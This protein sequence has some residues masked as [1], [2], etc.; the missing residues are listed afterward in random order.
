VLG[1]PVIGG[2]GNLTRVF[3]LFRTYAADPGATTDL[4]AVGKLDDLMTAVFVD[5]LIVGGRGTFADFGD[6]R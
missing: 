1:K 5:M 3:F 4:G 2:A 6:C